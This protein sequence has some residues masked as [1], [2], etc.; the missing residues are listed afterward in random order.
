MCI[1]VN[2]KNVAMKKSSVFK[3]TKNHFGLSFDTIDKHQNRFIRLSSWIRITTEQQLKF[4]YLLHS[5]D[6]DLSW[7][8]FSLL[9]STNGDTGIDIDCF[10][11]TK[12]FSLHEQDQEKRMVPRWIWLNEFIGKRNNC[13][14]K[15]W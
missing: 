8:P 4:N 13:F 15:L 6:S 9:I 12:L 3:L 14:H 10:G 11:L 5:R 7:H 2:Y 1:V